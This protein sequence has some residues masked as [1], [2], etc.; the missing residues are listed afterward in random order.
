MFFIKSIYLSIFIYLFVFYAMLYAI[1]YIRIRDVLCYLVFA[2]AKVWANSLKF[3]A[4]E[5]TEFCLPK[6]KCWYYQ[7]D[8]Y[9]YICVGGGVKTSENIREARQKR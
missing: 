7:L 9:I 6:R 1:D 3:R 8:A 4:A 5:N 2:I